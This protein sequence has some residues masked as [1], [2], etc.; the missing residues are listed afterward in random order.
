MMRLRDRSGALAAVGLIACLAAWPGCSRKRGVE[1]YQ[2]GEVTVVHNPE[3]PS[4]AP[5]GPSRLILRED[6]VIGR[7]PGPDRELFDSLNGIGVDDEDNIYA[8]D[9]ASVRIHVFDRNGRLLR[10]FG[11]R[12]Q[13][14]GELQDPADMDVRGDGA[15]AVL[16]SSPRRVV[17]YDRQGRYLHSSIFRTT[18]PHMGFEIDTRGVLYGVSLQKRELR[19]WRNRL[20]KYDEALTSA[21]EIAGI[22]GPDP[23]SDVISF[24]RPRLEFHLTRDDRLVWVNTSKYEFHVL[25][26][27]GRE[28]RRIVKDFRPLRIPEEGRREWI[29]LMT[30]GQPPEPDLKFE[31]PAA[32]PPVRT[33]LADEEGRIF[34]KTHE[35]DGRGGVWWDAL[36]VDGRFIARF[37]F[38]ENEM[39]ARV[40]KGK[41]YAQLEEDED[42]RPLLKRYTLD[43]K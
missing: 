30:G 23:P 14:P 24:F 25:D 18:W 5:G 6:L 40:K 2:D 43:W 39:A 9:G 31:F 13:G 26:R 27:G 38:P 16:D 42:G 20:F 4:P 34:V 33:F 22:E 21:E 35:N 1:I 12:G 37:L 28:I 29:Q 32:Y 11:S 19:T 15:V 41:L 36:D 3:T 10:S 7:G 8:W 17:F